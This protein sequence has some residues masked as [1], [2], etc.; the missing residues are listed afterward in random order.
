MPESRIS[1]SIVPMTMPPSVASA[2]S[3]SVNVMPS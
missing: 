3:I 1:A 2:V